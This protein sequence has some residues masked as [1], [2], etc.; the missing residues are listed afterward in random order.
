MDVLTPEPPPADHP[1]L[2]ANLDNLFITPHTA[3]S[4]KEARQRLIDGIVTNIEAFD[5]GVQ[6]NRVV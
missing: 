1:F 4:A 5:Q 6:R 2:A 3:W